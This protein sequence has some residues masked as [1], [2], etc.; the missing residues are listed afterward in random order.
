VRADKDIPYVPVTHDA[1]KEGV[2]GLPEENEGMSKNSITTFPSFV[3][4]CKNELTEANK[5]IVFNPTVRIFVFFV[6]FW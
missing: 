2:R 3:A 1:R 4:F 5:G 6:A